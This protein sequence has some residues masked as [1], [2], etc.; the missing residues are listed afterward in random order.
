MRR[1]KLP[2]IREIF[3]PDRPGYTIAEVDLAGAD[4]QVVAWEAQDADLKDAFRRGENIHEKNCIDLFGEVLAGRDPRHVVFE[5]A[6]GRYTYYD[7][8]K[9]S[10]HATNYVCTARTLALSLGWSI[11]YA[12]EFQSRWFERH[13]GISDWHRRVE[14]SL[15]L[16]RRV[17]NAWGYYCP[18]FARVEGLLPEGVAWIGQ[19]TVAISCSKG[20]DA[21]ERLYPLIQPLLQVHDS[22]VFQYKTSAE[23]EALT[24]A[25]T[26][27]DQIKV[28]Y[29]DDPME[30]K[31]SLK[32]SRV[33]W[34]A[35]KKAQWPDERT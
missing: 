18:F 1:F 29:P 23:L 31:W 32:T 7:C 22:I 21:L 19:S 28:P 17:R 3:I 12:Q 15:Q 8:L 11:A 27:L 10:V 16:E 5:G 4:A 26:A 33:S 6:V 24:A 25:K 13:P 20:W 34:G 9:R 2:N 35:C 30:L 14:R